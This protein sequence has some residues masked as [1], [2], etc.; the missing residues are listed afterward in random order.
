MDRNSIDTAV[1]TAHSRIGVEVTELSTNKQH[2]LL[3]RTDAFG[4]LGLVDV[5]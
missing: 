4:I 2:T 3:F 5:P 1:A